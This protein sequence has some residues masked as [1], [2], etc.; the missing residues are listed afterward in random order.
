MLSPFYK[1]LSN[2]L[3]TQL[4]E[5]ISSNDLILQEMLAYLPAISGQES[6][7]LVLDTIDNARLNQK[8]LFMLQADIEAAYDT[9]S[10][11]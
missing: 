7:R 4:K 5:A 9:L 6:V 8:D 2:M 3:S 1:I 11:D 10:K